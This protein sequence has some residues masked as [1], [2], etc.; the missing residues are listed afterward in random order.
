MAREWHELPASQR[1]QVIDRM[2]K[3]THGEWGCGECAFF[4]EAVRA[5]IRLA[6]ES[7]RTARAEKAMGEF[8]RMPGDKPRARTGRRK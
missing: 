2:P 7:T 6:R 5:L 8:S 3:S 4:D 1:N